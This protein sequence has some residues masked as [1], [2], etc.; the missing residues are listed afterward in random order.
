VPEE[1][2]AGHNQHFR[3]LDVVPFEEEEVAVRGVATGRSGV[4]R[5]PVERIIRL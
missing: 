1:I 4:A 2:I 5:N 3:V